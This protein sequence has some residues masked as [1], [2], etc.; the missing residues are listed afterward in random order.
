MSSQNL[1]F[2]ACEEKQAIHHAWISILLHTHYAELRAFYLLY[3]LLMVVPYTVISGSEISYS[4]VIY[5]GSNPG[6]T[7]YYDA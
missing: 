1:M 6:Y 3:M 7:Y 5:I 2:I 4:T